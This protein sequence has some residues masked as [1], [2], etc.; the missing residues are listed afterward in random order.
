MSRIQVFHFL[1][2]HRVGGPHVYAQT[3][4]QY[5][6]QKGGFETYY[7]TTAKGAITD[8]PLINLRHYWNPLYLLEVPLNAVMGTGLARRAKSI[9]PTVFHVHGA[10][11][12]APVI[13]AGLSGT[14]LLWTFH[15]TVPGFKKLVDLALKFLRPGNFIVTAVSHESTLVYG[16]P[17]AEILPA[18]VDPDFWQPIKEVPAAEE[19]GPLI[20]STAN[21]NPLKGQDVL[22]EALAQVPGPW[23]LRLIGQE[24]KTHQAFAKKLKVQAEAL[25][26]ADPSRS[27]EFLGWQDKEAVREQLK[28]T[29]VFVM[30]SR[31]E[32]TPI[33]LLEAL[34][35][36]RPA[37]ATQVGA[38]AQMIPTKE[39]GFLVPPENPKALAE[40]LTKA[41]ALSPEQ[42]T[43]MGESSRG[44][45]QK[46][47]GTAKIAGRVASLY[48]KLVKS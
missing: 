14:P 45:I 41:L 32:A 40:G 43:Q 5:L 9:G 38:V 6:E 46:N 27:V 11:N 8:I 36:G 37:V 10:A 13:A 29:Q 1:L 35:M 15:E 4:A 44:H 34:C 23:R 21:L 39:F 31:S 3:I 7:V 17:G 48:K 2:D 12:I 19:G 33:A 42:R 30:P 24:L 26:Q 20:L 25:C 22:L 16:T 47:Y 28:R 18:P